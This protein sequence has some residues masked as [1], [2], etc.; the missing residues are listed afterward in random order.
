MPH[1]AWRPVPNLSPS[2]AQNGFVSV[3]VGAELVPVQLAVRPSRN[4]HGKSIL[5]LT[6]DGKTCLTR[7]TMQSCKGWAEGMI[8]K[9]GKPPRER[10]FR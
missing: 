7:P 2:Q 9:M 6:V 3:P 4:S 8:V 1:I 5:C 10:H